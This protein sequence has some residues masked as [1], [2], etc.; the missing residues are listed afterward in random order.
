MFKEVKVKSRSQGSIARSGNMD[1]EPPFHYGLALDSRDPLVWLDIRSDT[2]LT[3]LDLVFR[4]PFL[5]LIYFNEALQIIDTPRL[6]W[7]R[8]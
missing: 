1:E 3:I 6:C 8:F 7:P 2:S 5:R 4:F